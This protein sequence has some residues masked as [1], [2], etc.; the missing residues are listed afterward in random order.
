VNVN[1]AIHKKSVGLIVG[2]TVASSAL[3]ASASGVAT[4]A[5][6]EFVANKR[7]ERI[8]RITLTVAGVHNVSDADALFQEYT[9]L[10]RNVTV[11][12]PVVAS[13][14]DARRHYLDQLGTGGL[15]DVQGIEADWLPEVMRHADLLADLTDPALDGRWLTWNTDAATDTNGRLMAYG[16]GIGPAG[17]C[18]DSALFADAGLPTDPLH[19]AALLEGDWATYFDMGQR[20]HEATGKAWFDDAGSTFEGMIN[21]VEAPY[22]DPATGTITPTTHPEV[23]AIYDQLTAVTPSLSAHLSQRSDDWFAGLAASEFAT[24]LCPVSMLGLIKEAAPDTSTWNV[25]DVFPGGGGNWGGAYLTVPASGKHVDAARELAAWLTEPEQQ[26][27]ALAA[28]GTFPSQRGAL[29]AEVALNAA[30]DGGDAPT[31]ATYFNSGALGTLFAN[32]AHAIG[33]TPFKGESYFQV[34]QAMQ[35]ALT[36]VEDGSQ[37]TATSWTQFVAEVEAIG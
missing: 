5:S 21:Q 22:E 10:R 19:V 36:R 25:A 26:L 11:V 1:F 15:A 2:V 13:T 4:E 29:T 37:D 24:M 18:Y 8:E 32:R 3:V 30:M 12:A 9:D 28:D 23:K 14:D 16:T 7:I 34:K 35:S 17:L 27:K 31:L 33:V 20:Y 6:A